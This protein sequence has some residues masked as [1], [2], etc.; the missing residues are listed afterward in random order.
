MVMGRHAPLG[1]GSEVAWALWASIVL[2]ASVGDDS[3]RKI[4]SM[5]DS[6]VAILMLDANVKGLVPPSID[7]KH[8]QSYMTTDE[9][10]G[11]Q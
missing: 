5:N 1:H 11:D 10:R 7:F 3:A 4:A 6:I 2:G 9:L 8:F